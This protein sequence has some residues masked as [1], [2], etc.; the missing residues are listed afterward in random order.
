MHT[1][2]D[3]SLNLTIVF[4]E[5]TDD[6]LVQEIRNQIDGLTGA[7]GYTQGYGFETWD[8]QVTESS[9]VTYDGSSFSSCVSGIFSTIA[10][11][12]VFTPS[13]DVDEADIDPYDITPLYRAL[14]RIVSDMCECADQSFSTCPL[15]RYDITY[16]D[17]YDGS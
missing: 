17:Q 11:A 1:N 5:H 8:L 12:V 10:L 13:V 15:D 16:T 14:Q 4:K 2:D 9:I 6:I 7:W 3:V